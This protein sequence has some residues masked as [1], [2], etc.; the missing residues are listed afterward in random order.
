VSRTVGPARH[1]RFP[2]LIVLA[3][4]FAYCS[5]A[6]PEYHARESAMSRLIQSIDRHPALYGPRLR[7]IARGCTCPEVR[8]RCTRILAGYDRWRVNSFVPTTAPVWPICDAFPVANP[9]VPF[10]LAPDV[11]DKLRWPVQTMHGD[12]SGPY[13]TAYR[14]TTAAHVRVMLLDGVDPADVQEL[15]ARMWRLECRSCGDVS[16][17]RWA[18]SEGWTWCGG[19]PPHV[20]PSPTSVRRR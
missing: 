16:A 12:L 10:A 7:E 2:P 1:P 17:E 3:L 6:D 18:V 4:L 15:L 8:A 11:R 19:L 9:F 13:W 14:R 20:T 5:L